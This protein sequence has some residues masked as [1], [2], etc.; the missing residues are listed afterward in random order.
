MSSLLD[1]LAEGALWLTSEIKWR[2]ENPCAWGLILRG[3][4]DAC[5][6]RG[7]KRAAAR[8]RRRAAR[9][10]NK[11]KAKRLEDQRDRVRKLG[12]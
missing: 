10:E 4:A 5:E 11:C 8:A 3:R 12:R 2:R 6:Q 7:W 1:L 9:A